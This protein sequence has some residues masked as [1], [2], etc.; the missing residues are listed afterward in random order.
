[1]PITTPAKAAASARAAG[2]KRR[3]KRAAAP[4][5]PVV[6]FRDASV[7]DMDDICRLVDLWAE[8]G[9]NLPRSRDE[10]LE[11]ITDFGVVT[12]DGRVAGCASLWIYTPSLAE[13]RSLGVDEQTHGKGLGSGLV[14]YFLERARGLGIPRVF[15]L[16]RAPKFFERCGFRQ[17]SVNSL[18]EKILK[19]CAKCPKN[20]CCDEIAMVIDTGAVIDAEIDPTLPP[21]GSAPR[22]AGDRGGSG[23]SRE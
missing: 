4:A 18:P 12:V 21:P 6:E 23:A 17:V 9:E 5:A 19:D 20:T 13:I 7:E 1:A 22:A 10:I 3:T 15:V 8:R 11:K 14:Q 2:R 16:T